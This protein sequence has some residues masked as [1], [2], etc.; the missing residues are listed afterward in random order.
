MNHFSGLI[1]QNFKDIFNQAIDSLLE[2]GA[3]SAPCKLYYNNE[4][5]DLS[6]FCDN[7]V[8]DPI[9]QASAGIF[10]ITDGY[11]TFPNGSVCPVCNGIGKII[12]DS[13]EILH[14]AVILDSKYW[15]NY[16]PK[17]VQIPDLAAQTLCRIEFMPK[18]V[19]ATSMTMVETYDYSP[20]MYS[21]VGTPVPMGFGNHKYILTN[22][23]K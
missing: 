3:L 23:T 20:I 2:V 14:L 8:Y 15:L 4:F 16:G 12:L 5:S 9:S 22:W 17:N 10:N 21:K 6:V 11:A 1:N 18:I 7:C 13:N 19:K